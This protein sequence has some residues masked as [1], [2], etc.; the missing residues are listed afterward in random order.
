LDAGLESL[1]NLRELIL[2]HNLI[3]EIE[4]L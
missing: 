1:T 4:G 3:S 2:N